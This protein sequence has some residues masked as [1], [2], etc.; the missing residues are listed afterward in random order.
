MINYNIIPQVVAECE[1]WKWSA[2]SKYHVTMQTTA[3]FG[4]DLAFN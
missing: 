2:C 1:M 3:E 4:S